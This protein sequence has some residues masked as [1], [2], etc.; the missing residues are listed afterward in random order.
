MAAKLFGALRKVSG[1]AGI[2]PSRVAYFLNVHGPTYAV[3]T[4]C[5]SGLL[6]VHL[7]AQSIRGGEADL[8]ICG[9]SFLML[10]PGTTVMTAKGGGLSADGKIRAFGAGANGTVF[11]EGVCVVVL[12]DFEREYRSRLK[13]YF[14]SQLAALDGKGNGDVPLTP[15]AEGDTPRRLRELLGEEQQQQG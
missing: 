15:S 2:A 9:G 12:K 8:A 7:G 1:S 10:T 11:G 3:D 13:S 4:A 6:A 5:S 14:E